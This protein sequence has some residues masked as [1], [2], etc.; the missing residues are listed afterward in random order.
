[1]MMTMMMTMMLM[2]MMWW[3][4]CG[5]NLMIMID[6]IMPSNSTNACFLTSFIP[7]FLPSFLLL[8]F[9]LSLS[10]LPQCRSMHLP[11]CP[12]ATIVYFMQCFPSHPMFYTLSTSVFL[13]HVLSLSTSSPFVLPFSCYS[14]SSCFF[15]ISRFRIL[16]PIEEKRK[17]KKA[18]EKQAL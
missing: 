9:L 15:L 7:S 5:Y 12:H 14:S 1:M 10:F 3:R 2:I 13:S 18:R 6:G 8:F 11:P 4:C 17:E 16:H